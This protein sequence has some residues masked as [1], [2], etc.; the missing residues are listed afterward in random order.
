MGAKGAVTEK[1]II[2]TIMIAIANRLSR[3]V[4]GTVAIENWVSS[5]SVCP[6]NGPPEVSST[7]QD[8]Q[9]AD[10]FALGR[11]PPTNMMGIV[12]VAALAARVEAA[13]SDFQWLTDQLAHIVCIRAKLVCRCR[14]WVR[15]DRF[16]MSEPCPLQRPLSTHMWI[17]SIFTGEDGSTIYFIQP[18]F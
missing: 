13:C 9:L 4:G 8:Y 10:P 6:A 16:A 7:V 12:A 3:G 2:K 15:S 11:S 14:S 18:L 17:N 5:A 1:P